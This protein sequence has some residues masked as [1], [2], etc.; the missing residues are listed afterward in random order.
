M[1]D[2]EAGGLGRF[3]ADFTGGAGKKPNQLR[4]RLHGRCEA[5]VLPSLHAPDFDAHRAAHSRPTGAVQNM[6]KLPNLRHAGFTLIELLVVIAI[7]AILAGMLLPAL[8]KAK[9]KA[10][11]VK[12]NSNLRQLGI[13]VRM[14]ADDNR[15][16]LPN[17]SGAVWPWDIP[18]MAA[19]AIVKNGGT[20]AILYCPAFSKQNNNQ[21]WSFSTGV[22]NEVIANESNTGYRVIGYAVAFQ[23]AGRIRTTNITESYNPKPWRI[24][25]V[26]VQVG[27]SDRVIVADG[28]IS[29]GANEANRAQNRYTK[30]DGGWAGHQSP[31]LNGKVPAGG[32]HL[33]LDGHTSWVKFEKMKVRTDGDPS[34]WW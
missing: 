29:Q 1:G 34:F 11:Q 23:G 13:A 25:G 24:G 7:I 2:P 16:M 3:H 19:N 30:I 26:D 18:A 17:C 5:T 8:S 10:I 4:V 22:T 32:N 9:T 20:R 28:T 14:Y 27:P 6:K 15:D 33:Y 31:H 12:C 21:L